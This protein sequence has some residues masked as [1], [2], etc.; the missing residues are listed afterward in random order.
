[1]INL[2]TMITESMW[3]ITPP[4]LQAIVELIQDHKKTF[5]KEVFHGVS[6][7]DSLRAL[8]GTVGDNI[9]G[10]TF[11]SRSGR[12]GILSIDGPII[13][14]SV[15]TPSSGP[16]GSLEKYSQELILMDNNPNIDNIVITF[17]SP[18]GMVTGVEEFGKLIKSL[19]TPVTAFVYGYSASAAYWIASQASEIV[20]AETAQVGSIGTVA[21]F[22]D[23]SKAEEKAG[24][25]T[26]EIVSNLSPNKRLDPESDTGRANIISMLDDI[27]KI[28]MSSVADGRGTNFENVFNNFGQGKMFIASKAIELGM[29]D[30]IDTLSNLLNELNNKSNTLNA[31]GRMSNQT[32]P[33]LISAVSAEDFKSK[34]PSVFNE[35]FNA[36]V[37]AERQRLQAIE[38]LIEKDK[39]V[40]SFVNSKKFEDEMTKEKMALAIFENKSEI[41][42]QAAENVATNGKKLA[43]LASNVASSTDYQSHND[44]NDDSVNNMIAGAKQQFK[45]IHRH[46]LGVN[47]HV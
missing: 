28:F 14:K 8:I 6:D 3:A 17:D 34:N 45:K 5:S 10:T 35:I 1:M 7:E 36:G 42:K 11:S 2:M 16:M 18:G 30:R 43:E 25:R 20:M 12:V 46:E 29:A 9:N 19:Q 40:F 39:T 23:R 38:T 27:T 22:Q 24:I 31:G 47:K 21:V 41:L 4:S 26:F 15:I 33:D 37:Q 44:D 13:P 32:Q